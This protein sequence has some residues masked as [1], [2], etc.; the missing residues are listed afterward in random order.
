MLEALD[1][2]PVARSCIGLGTQGAVIVWR[3]TERITRVDLAAW[4]LANDQTRVVHQ[5]GVPRRS[6]TIEKL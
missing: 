2:L 6:V 1:R 3:R 5:E 4:P